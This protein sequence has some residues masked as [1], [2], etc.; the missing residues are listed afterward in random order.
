M[1]LCQIIANGSRM[2]QEIFNLH[3]RK[4][5]LLLPEVW[6]GL[7]TISIFIIKR[8]TA[9]GAIFLNKKGSVIHG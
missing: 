3:P 6:H 5:K 2:K 9:H 1:E 4:P 7:E 8:T